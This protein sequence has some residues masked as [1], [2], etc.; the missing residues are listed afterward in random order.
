MQYR[1]AFAKC[2]VLPEALTAAASDC[3]EPGVQTSI[4]PRAGP[5]GPLVVF[6][7]R[8][9]PFSIEFRM[10]D[11]PDAIPG[12][13]A[14]E[15]ADPKSAVAGAEQPEYEPI[16]QLL[17]PRWLPGHSVNTIESEQAEFTAEPEIPVRCLGHRKDVARKETIPEDPRRVAV[18]ADLERRIKCEGGGAESQQSRRP[19]RHMQTRSL[20]G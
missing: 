11:Q 6:E 14:R 13:K 16:R 12:Y 20:H 1:S 10:A 5:D 19:Q 17:P 7:Q 9:D 15:G 8:T 4:A 18:L 3:A 2:A